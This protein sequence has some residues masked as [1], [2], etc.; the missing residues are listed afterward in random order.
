MVKQEVVGN[1]M[2]VYCDC[3]GRMEYK[4][5]R[6]VFSCSKCPFEIPLSHLTPA[7][8]VSGENDVKGLSN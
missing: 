1:G 3:G 8:P 6:K 4:K 2:K 5:K 7:Q